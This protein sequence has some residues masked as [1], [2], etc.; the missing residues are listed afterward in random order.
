MY[1]LTHNY[2]SFQTARDLQSDCERM[3]SSDV[4]VVSVKMSSAVYAR[5]K[6]TVRMTLAGKM[7]SFGGTLGLFTGTR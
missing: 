2:N 6:R 3:M 7:A 1:E 5:S 4:A